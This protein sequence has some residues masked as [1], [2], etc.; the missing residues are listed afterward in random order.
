[1]EHFPR[2]ARHHLA[3]VHAAHADGEH[4]QAAAVRGMRIGADYQAARER[5]VLERHLV[6]DPRARL[7]E[8]DAVLLRHGVQEVVD[9]L[10]LLDGP[11]EV[12]GGAR[13]RADQMVAVDG[14]RNGHA[15]APR[16]HELEQGHLGGG[17][18]QSHAVHAQPEGRLAPIPGLCGEILGVRHQDLVG[19]REGPTQPLPCLIQ[20]LAH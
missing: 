4:A 15:R 12:G 1:M 17:V 9:L 5:V 7:P 16:L 2:Q 14:G 10:V 19:Q 3:A 11:R 6:D 20:T 13:L 8:L 18:L